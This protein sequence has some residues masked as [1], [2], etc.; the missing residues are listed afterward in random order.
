MKKDDFPESDF[1]T[2]MRHAPITVETY[3]T[4]MIERIDNRF[5]QG[6]SK[7]HP[8]FLA[9]MV[10]HCVA[11]FNN[12]AIGRFLHGVAEAIEYSFDN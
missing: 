8:E 10:G 9:A 3:M 5:G 4:A 6:Y 12:G 11:D 7:A 1:T 2:L